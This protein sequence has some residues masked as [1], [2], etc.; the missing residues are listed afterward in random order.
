MRSVQVEAALPKDAQ[1]WLDDVRFERAGEVLGVSDKTITQYMAEAAACH[2]RRVVETLSNPGSW[3]AF[4]LTAPLYNGKDLEAANK[5]V[6]AWAKEGDGGG[7]Q[8]KWTLTANS[9]ANWLLFGFGSKGRIAPGRLSPEAERAVLD[10][11]WD[12]CE[13]KN[14]IATARQGWDAAL[15]MLNSGDYDM[16]ILDEL[17]IVLKYDY[18]PLDEVLAALAA[19]PANLHVVITGRHAPQA[20]IDAADLVTEMKL[21]KHP[22]REQGIKAQ[23]GVEF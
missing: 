22:Y 20:L 1:L 11:Y 12:H 5:A 14:D 15:E 9:Y 8:S 17:N 21:V 2:A 18:L 19:R 13:V 10:Y 3:A 23:Q 4:S 6:I 16:L 7:K